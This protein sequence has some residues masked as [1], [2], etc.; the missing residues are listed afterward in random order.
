MKCSWFSGLFQLGK[1]H[2][3]HTFSDNRQRPFISPFTEVQQ[4]SEEAHWGHT[5]WKL[6]ISCIHDKMFSNSD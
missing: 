3:L 6:K 5:P 4:K 2:A 1:A